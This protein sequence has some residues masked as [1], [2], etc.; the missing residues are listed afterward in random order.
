M[1]DCECIEANNPVAPYAARKH[2][3]PVE[4][5]LKAPPSSLCEQL[6]NRQLHS[7]V[8]VVPL[9][10]PKLRPAFAAKRGRLR[11]EYG[12]KGTQRQAELAFDLFF[13]GTLNDR[14]VQCLG[15]AA[16][17]NLRMCGRLL[18]L[19][20]SIASQSRR[21]PDQNASD[22][23]FLSAI[24]TETTKPLDE[25]PLAHTTRPFPARHAP[26]NH[27]AEWQG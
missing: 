27:R 13:K 14:K 8:C 23:A 18:R 17:P 12:F 15:K 24:I 25:L 16:L 3:T 9:K 10:D 21:T 11:K 4:S 19:L 5:Q 26:S 6:L 7:A 20:A 2:L 1:A 22:R